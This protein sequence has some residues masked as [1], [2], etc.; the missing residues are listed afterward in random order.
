MP[1]RDG[2]ARPAG[3]P[4]LDRLPPE[5]DARDSFPTGA[6]DDELELHDVRVVGAG[7]TR[8]GVLERPELVN[9]AL[10]RCD[11]AGL[12]ARNGRA[13]RLHVAHSRLRGLT[14]A[15][16]ALQDV[17][18]DT[19]TGSDVSLRFST[20]QRVTFRD[21]TLPGLDLT[22]TTLDQVRFER[23][24]LPA[25]QFHGAKVKD[26]RIAGCDLT[27]CTGAESLAGASVHPDDLLTLAPSLA[28]A[29]GL[30][31][32]DGEDR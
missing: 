25:A 13:A 20:L 21:C 19:V 5:E 28:H 30:T 3:A 32:D 14:W 23:C 9:V 10:E 12:V 17:V 26:L 15:G 24:A 4:W 18:V 8:T 22:E 6:G 1:S 11:V 31:L 16:G 29:L 27:G 7:A 2:R